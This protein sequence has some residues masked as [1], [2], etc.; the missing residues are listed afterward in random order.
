SVND[1][2]ELEAVSQSEAMDRLDQEGFKTNHE[3]RLVDDIEAVIEYIEYWTSHRNGLDYDIDGIVVKVN[4]ISKQDRMGF[5]AKS[6]RWAIAY[7]FPAEEV[8]T[9]II[10]IERTVGRT[11]GIN[12]TD[13][14]P[15]G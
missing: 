12:P 2:T 6:P 1:L 10:D 8:V 11:G 3:R 13:I 9:D 5:T 15:P 14:L 4:E 7:K